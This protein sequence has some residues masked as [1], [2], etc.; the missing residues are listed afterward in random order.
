MDYFEHD[1][2][3]R[4]GP[5]VWLS[6]LLLFLGLERLFRLDQCIREYAALRIDQVLG[7]ATRREWYR[8]LTT[9]I[10]E[11]H[12]LIRSWDHLRLNDLRASVSKLKSAPMAQIR[13]IFGDIAFLS[14]VNHF[15]GHRGGDAFLTKVGKILRAVA[16]LFCI[17]GRLGGDEVAVAIDSTDTGFVRKVFLAIEQGVS[18]IE[19]VTPINRS[20]TGR[21][22]LGIASLKQAIDVFAQYLDT[23]GDDELF[24]EMGSRVS[25]LVDILVA[26]ADRRSD[27]AKTFERLKFLTWLYANDM[28]AYVDYIGF[29][30]K[31]GGNI[32][33]A[34]VAELIRDWQLDPETGN[35]KPIDET[36]FEKILAILAVSMKQT[37]GDLNQ[38]IESVAT[39]PFRKKY[40]I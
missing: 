28:E 34:E 36:A 12:P 31:G 39:A 4:Y 10:L 19:I 38:L 22:D 30:R 1:F 17:P 3:K 11:K 25:T 20:L 29:F 6:K 8:A 33:D 37:E 15:S 35:R 26:L 27:V 9:L 5:L 21:I 2:K 18:E 40:A 32:S 13:V 24:F 7:I 23:L 16:N 14:L